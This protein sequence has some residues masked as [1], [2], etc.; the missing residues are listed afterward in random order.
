MSRRLTAAPM[1]VKKGP[2]EGLVA[3]ML[4]YGFFRL[5]TG[6]LALI[7]GIISKTS[8]AIRHDR[9]G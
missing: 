6:R 1:P 3:A 9:R 4:R 5:D 7:S 2:D 8:I